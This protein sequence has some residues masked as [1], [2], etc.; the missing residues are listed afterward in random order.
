M[1]WRYNTIWFDQVDRDKIISWNYKE[2]KGLSLQFDIEEYAI[3]WY[4]RKKGLSFE[5]I[6]QSEKLLYL[7]LNWANIQ[8]FCGVQRFPNLKRLEL[9]YCTKL[10]NDY[11]LLYL[12]DTIEHL[13]INQSKKFQST[14]E[15]SKLKNLKVLRLNNC[16]P[17]KSIAFL[18]DLPNLIDFRFV[19]TNILDGDLTPIID[20]PSLKSVGFFNKRHYN[21]TT[22]K[23]NAILESKLK[24]EYQDFVY[25]DQY[26]TFKY[27]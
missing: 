8:D 1:D 15:I 20:H 7:E 16:G 2:K 18:K 11:G 4:Y 19:D 10:E 22:E 5:S 25:K 12:E 14:D 17:L 9:Y 6:P 13:H 21:N 3:L 27:K 26:K 23:I 24:D